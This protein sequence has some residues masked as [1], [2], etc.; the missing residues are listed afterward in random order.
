MMSIKIALTTSPNPDDHFLTLIQ[1]LESSSLSPVLIIYVKEHYSKRIKRVL[2]NFG[3]HEIICRLLVKRKRNRK[4][5][6]CFYRKYASDIYCNLKS[7]V[8]P[9]IKG[10]NIVK[11][12]DINCT[13]IAEM[14]KKNEV[15]ILI[16]GGGG[17][18]REN[19]IKSVNIGILNAHMG[20]LPTYRGINV[21]EWSIFKNDKIIST[22]HFIDKYIDSGDILSYREIRIE[23]GD[24]IEDLRNKSAWEGIHTIL[25]VINQITNRELKRMKQ[26]PEEG[27]QYFVMHER[28]KNIIQKKL[29]A[30]Q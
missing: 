30:Y 25:E 26:L 14:L 13:R 23:K 16:Y 6:N 3:V 4:S 21:L 15:D 19:I 9:D 11:T 20:Q 29:K 1:Y 5:N 17:I 28:L 12:S 27:K 22:V 7:S 10:L 2:N 8:L 24:T 18:F